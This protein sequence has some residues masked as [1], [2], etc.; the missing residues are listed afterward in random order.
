MFRKSSAQAR[1][2]AVGRGG[3]ADAAAPAPEPPPRGDTPPDDVNSAS[4]CQSDGFPSFTDS[5]RAATASSRRFSAMQLRAMTW[6]ALYW[7]RGSRCD[8]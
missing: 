6:Y 4:S 3:F 5:L 7:K 1:R 2:Y 8:E